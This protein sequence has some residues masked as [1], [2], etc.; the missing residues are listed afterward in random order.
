MTIVFVINN[1]FRVILNLVMPLQNIKNFVTVRMKSGW[2]WCVQRSRSFLHVRRW[3]SEVTH[4]FLGLTCEAHVSSL[5]TAL[6]CFCVFVL[7]FEV[8]IR[9]LGT[10]TRGRTVVLLPRHW[11]QPSG[12]GVIQ[13]ACHRAP[14]RTFLR[15]EMF[16][17]FTFFL[18]LSIH[19]IRKHRHVRAQG[20]WSKQETFA[21][22]RADVSKVIQKFHTFTS[23]KG[24]ESCTD[25]WQLLCTTV[26][27]PFMHVLPDNSWE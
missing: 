9:M 2:G 7:F 6:R 23:M 10:W 17:Y 21:I 5:G 8:S 24:Q 25:A 4:E 18:L 26:T 27:T 11:W 15:P 19:I 3:T 12:S 13:E 16:V 1:Y 20:Q 22:N 14:L